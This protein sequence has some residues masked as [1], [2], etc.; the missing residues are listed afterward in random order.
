MLKNDEFVGNSR[1][2]FNQYFTLY[3][4][5]MEDLRMIDPVAYNEIVEF[6]NMQSAALKTK[7]PTDCEDALDALPSLELRTQKYSYLGVHQL[8]PP[9]SSMAELRVCLL[10]GP[11][12]KAKNKFVVMV[13]MLANHEYFQK[14]NHDLRQIVETII[15]KSILLFNTHKPLNAKHPSPTSVAAMALTEN[16]SST[17]AIPLP[18]LTLKVLAQQQQKQLLAAAASGEVMHL[19]VIKTKRKPGSKKKFDES[20]SGSKPSECSDESAASSAKKKRPS[21]YVRKAKLKVLQYVVPVVDSATP[22]TPYR[23]SGDHGAHT[24]ISSSDDDGSLAGGACMPVHMYHTSNAAALRGVPQMPPNRKRGDTAIEEES[25]L[26]DDDF[27]MTEECFE[28]LMDFSDWDADHSRP[29]LDDS[30][31]QS[32]MSIVLN[33]YLHYCNSFHHI[34]TQVTTAIYRLKTC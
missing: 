34:F 27:C 1:R 15:A 22:F 2:H 16:S 28:K 24:D 32:G 31:D 33:S 18:L 20:V 12:S 23:L 8:T 29:F 11:P 6:K 5:I 14:Y 7:D 26:Y 4:C 30:V 10:D 17:M 25:A 9:W 19:A 3:E 13:D 21:T